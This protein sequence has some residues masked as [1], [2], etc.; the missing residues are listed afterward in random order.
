MNATSPFYLCLVDDPVVYTVTGCDP[1][2]SVRLQFLID[3]P[4]LIDNTETVDLIIYADAHGYASV[5]ISDILIP[6]T[7]MLELDD[8]DM[9]FGGTTFSL[10]YINDEA[11]S[12]DEHLAI[13]GSVGS[14]NNLVGQNIYTLIINQ[15]A[16]PF[17]THRIVGN[18][19]SF[20]RS[21]L[22]NADLFFVKAEDTSLS[23]MLGGTISK[24]VYYNSSSNIGVLKGEDLTKT[25][26]V[27]ARLRKYYFCLATLLNEDN[28]PVAE[29]TININDDP[30][31][32]EMHLFRFINSFGVWE[33]MLMTGEAQNNPEAE[34]P[35]IFESETAA[36]V[37]QKSMQRRQLTERYSLSTGHL[38]TARLRTLKDLLRSEQVQIL[39]DNEWYDCKTTASIDVSAIIRT[40]QSVQLDVELLLTST[41]ANAIRIEGSFE[42]QDFLRDHDGDIITNQ[43][44]NPITT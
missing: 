44:N 33:C 39:I 2:A 23:V 16:N 12:G 29:Y 31:C 28:E 22:K 27:G 36:Y 9:I 20:Y 24:T 8:D 11:I 14:F 21:E 25:H 5:N 7:P 10:T 13:R 32:D 41:G 42:D 6:Y 15:N 17:L 1:Y 35:E 4:F 19:V 37:R 26:R 43:D 34:D 40:P 18:S 30:E 3:N 38:D